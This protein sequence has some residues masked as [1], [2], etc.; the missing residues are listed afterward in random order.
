M[1][2]K[3]IV[4]G[5]FYPGNAAQIRRFI[6]RHI[7]SAAG[8]TAARGIIVPHAGYP[9]SGEVAIDVFRRILPRKK[10]IV[11][12]PN[13]SGLGAP[14]ALWPSGYWHVPGAAIPVDEELAGKILEGDGPITADRDAHLREHSIEVELPL[15]NY[16]FPEASIVPICL[17]TMDPGASQ[18]CAAQL[19]GAI[20]SC[21]DEILLVASSDMSHYEPD[22]S[23]RRKDRIALED[24]LNLDAKSLQ[25][26]VR[27]HS[28]SMC[29]LAPVSI[30]IECMRIF[31]RRKAQVIKYQ[32]SGDVT[33]DYDAV[34][35]Y[36]GVMV[37]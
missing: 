3:P 24:I 16:F 26:H 7:Q 11:L 32:T 37:Q 27:E 36:A 17:Q 13:H 35:G 4:D 5:R 30:L 1:D 22:A 8:Y 14:A 10:I 34:V 25:R 33:G 21:R 18:A 19:T 12:G 20:K 28:I 6:D 15:L 23:A 29:G 9:Y 31:G 2:R